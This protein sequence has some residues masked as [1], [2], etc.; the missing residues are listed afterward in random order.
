M[1]ERCVRD[2]E[3]VGSNPVASIYDHKELSAINLMTAPYLIADM[4]RAG[5]ILF[6]L[7]CYRY[8]VHD[9]FKDHICGIYPRTIKKILK[10]SI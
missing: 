1:V 10:M 9:I 8:P 2:A 4:V 3:A 6:L 7:S 5:T